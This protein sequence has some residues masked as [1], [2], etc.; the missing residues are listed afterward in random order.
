MGKFS[1]FNLPLKSLP[2]GT[3]QFEY[4]LDKQFFENMESADIRDADVSVTLEV[5]YA[6]D[7]YDLHFTVKGSVVVPCDRC[8][9]DLTLDIDTTYSVKVKYGEEYRDDSDDIMEIPESDSTLNVANM[10]Y[11]TVSL[12]IPIKHVHPMGKCNRAMSSL[13]KKHR[14]VAANDAD[15]ELEDELIEE[16]DSMPESSD[17]SRDEDAPSDPRW[18]KLK[19]LQ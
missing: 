18:D 2:K 3:H 9:D 5:T 14:A 10:I 11:D 7:V 13:L 6:N 19:D 12:A 4:H 17:D 16:M 1:Q 8:L 15:A